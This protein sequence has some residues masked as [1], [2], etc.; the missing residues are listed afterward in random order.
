M[1]YP[2]HLFLPLPTPTQY[3]GSGV[4]FR[5]LGEDEEVDEAEI[6]EAGQ[7]DSDD[8]SEEDR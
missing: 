3:S 2:Q 1:N 5:Q 6:L 7:Y 8:N 4:E